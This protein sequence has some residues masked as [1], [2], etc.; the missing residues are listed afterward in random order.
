MSDRRIKLVIMNPPRFGKTILDPEAWKSY[1]N[2]HNKFMLGLETT[3]I[4]GRESM[5]MK[6]LVMRTDVIKPKGHIRNSDYWPLLVTINSQEGAPNTSR[7]EFYEYV[8][9]KALDVVSESYNPNYQYTIVSMSNAVN[10]QRKPV[11]PEYRVTLE[12]FV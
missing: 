4:L 10:I 1:Y 6:Y 3:G 5:D 2:F 7:N 9:R 8:L 11:E 12:E